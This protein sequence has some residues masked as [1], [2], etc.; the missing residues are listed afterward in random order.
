MTEN[1][2]AYAQAQRALGLFVGVTTG[3]SEE[4]QTIINAACAQLDRSLQMLLEAAETPE[5]VTAEELSPLWHFAGGEGLYAALPAP[6][7]FVLTWTKGKTQFPL[8]IL[9]CSSCPPDEV[10]WRDQSNYIFSGRVDYWM[11]IPPVERE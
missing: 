4:R 8:Q 5:V 10:I 9:R 2:D 6:G 3:L 7:E 1:I 11:P